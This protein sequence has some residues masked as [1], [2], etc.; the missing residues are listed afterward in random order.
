[1]V[2]EQAIDYVVAVLVGIIRNIACDEF[3]SE[4]LVR[5]NVLCILWSTVVTAAL[6]WPTVQVGVKCKK[7]VDIWR[8]WRKR[9]RADTGETRLQGMEYT[10]TVRRRHELRHLGHLTCKAKG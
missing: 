9:K 4:S 6:E 1:M 10:V 3:Y 2:H 5:V 8:G 7:R